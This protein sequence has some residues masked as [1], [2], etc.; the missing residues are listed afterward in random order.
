MPTSPK[1]PVYWNT[2]GTCGTCGFAIPSK[3]LVMTRKHGWQCLPGSGRTRGCFDG[4]FDRDDIYFIYP[5]NEGTRD[6]AAPLADQ[7]PGRSYT[8]YVFVDSVTGTLYAVDTTITPWVL[9]EVDE[10]DPDTQN[11]PFDWVENLNGLRYYVAN[12]EVFTGHFSV[13]YCPSAPGAGAGDTTQ[14]IPSFTVIPPDVE[15]PPPNPPDPPTPPPIVLQVQEEWEWIF[16]NGDLQVEEEWEWNEP[17]I[18]T[19]QVDEEWES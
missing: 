13:I 17:T 12:G 11:G 19:E 14:Q 3:Y 18:G 4:D 7:N 6:T 1:Y 10:V 15:P 8:V 9:V 2:W 5:D 16:V